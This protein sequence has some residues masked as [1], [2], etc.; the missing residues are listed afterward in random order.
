MKYYV[1]YSIVGFRGFA[2]GPYASSD[3]ASEHE[4]DIRGYEG[5][6]NVF[7]INE[8]PSDEYQQLG[9]SK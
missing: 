6:H 3:E 5:V 2:A 8:E 7:V 1:C 9:G 4:R